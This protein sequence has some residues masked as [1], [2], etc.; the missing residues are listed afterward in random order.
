M[1]ENS[2]DFCGSACRV[3]ATSPPPRDGLRR[4]PPGS[5]PSLGEPDR[6]RQA[7]RRDLGLVDVVQRAG[8]HHQPRRQVR[9]GL[10]DSISTAR[11]SPSLPAGSSGAR[12]CRCPAGDSRAGCSRTFP[13][14]RGRSPSSPPA[15]SVRVWSGRLG[16]RPPYGRAVDRVVVDQQDA[17]S[18]RHDGDYAGNSTTFQ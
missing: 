3:R 8:P 18:V 7:G 14:R 15:A 6:P 4:V 17:G 5:A 13:R 1:I 10:A 9:V 12:T 16:E 2:S 11:A